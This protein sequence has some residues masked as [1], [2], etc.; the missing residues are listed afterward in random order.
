MSAYGPSFDDDDLHNALN[1]FSRA[2]FPG[3]IAEIGQRK[4]FERKDLKP[5]KSI[6]N[7]KSFDHW[8]EKQ[9]PALIFYIPQ[10]LAKPVKRGNGQYQVDFQV[11]AGVL[12]K[13]RDQDQTRKLLSAYMT[14]VVM[15][16]LQHSS[17]SPDGTSANRV[18]ES[19][20][21]LGNDYDTL[22]DESSRTIQGGVVNLGISISHAVDSNT[23]L[24]IPPPDPLVTPPEFG[25][26]ETVEVAVQELAV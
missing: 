7:L 8:P 22:G 13:G 3:Y 11:G 15:M 1:V 12:V 10:T 26:V 5:F 2:W 14:A 23:G 16:F 20:E 19:I 21:W 6:S 18:A 9:L 25:T 24:S 4:G 17:L